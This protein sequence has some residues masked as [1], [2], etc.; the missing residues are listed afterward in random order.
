MKIEG[1]CHCRAV[2]FAA[3]LPDGFASARRCNCSFCAMRGAV[4]VSTPLDAFEITHGAEDLTLYTFNTG[5]AQH[6][7]C[8]HCGIY[9]H[10][11]RRSDPSEFGINL[12]CI[13]D[14]SPFL[15]HVDVTDGRNHTSDGAPP[16]IAGIL[17]YEG[18]P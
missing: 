12:A 8:R 5:T 17:R 9:T 7:F 13:A 6:Y 1:A 14:Q 10:H 18:T 15:P 16:R 4:A 11:R 3:T 2:R